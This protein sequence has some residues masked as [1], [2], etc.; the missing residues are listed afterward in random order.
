MIKA[1][2]R[3]AAIELA[4]RQ[5]K[6]KCAIADAIA[7]AYPNARCIKVD[8][9]KIRFSDVKTRVRYEYQTPPNARTFVDHW[10]SGDQVMPITVNLA[11]KD[12]IKVV[13]MSSSAP[14]RVLP[15]PVHNPD[16]PHRAKT[17]RGQ[18]NFRHIHAESP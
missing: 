16:R 10:D 18:S 1:R 17:V 4:Q 13:P 11:D 12:L 7:Y 6:G 15:K 9:D 3:Q 8:R 14:T 5:N 2:V